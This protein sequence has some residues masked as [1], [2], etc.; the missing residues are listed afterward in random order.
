MDGMYKYLKDKLNDMRII[1]ADEITIGYQEL[2]RMFQIVC[3]MKQIKETV[4]WG[5][6]K[7]E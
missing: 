1:G 6:N 3:L 2:A 5:D 7:Y 4:S